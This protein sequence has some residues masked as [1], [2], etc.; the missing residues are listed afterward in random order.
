LKLFGSEDNNFLAS[1]V[2]NSTSIHASPDWSICRFTLEVDQN[3]G[4]TLFL[5]I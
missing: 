4:S 1:A 5:D 3:F 2:L